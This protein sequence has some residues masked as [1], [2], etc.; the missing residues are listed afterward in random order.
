MQDTVEQPN[1]QNGDSE[2]PPL[3]LVHPG[4]GPAHVAHQEHSRG[5]VSAAVVR[6][7]PYAIV[8]TAIF[9]AAVPLVVYYA[10][11]VPR[12]GYVGLI[13]LGLMAAASERLSMLVYGEAK[14]SISFVCLF[15]IA[16]LYGPA[17]IVLATPLSILAL[18]FPRKVRHVDFLFNMGNST[19]ADTASAIVL[20]SIIDH[21]SDIAISARV[22]TAGLLAASVNYGIRAVLISGAV[23]V[24][25]KRNLLGVW[26]EKFQWL[27]PHYI[28]FGFLGLALAVAYQQLGVT[29][30]LAFA[31]PPLMMRFSMKQYIDNTTRHVAMLRRK[32]EQLQRANREILGMSERLRETYD[33]TLE[34][35]AA[36]LDARDSE[37]GGHS[38][39]VT[40]YTMDMAEE[41]GVPKGSD[42]WL[43]IERASLLHDVGK[44]G[45]SDA[46]L[47]KPGPLTSEEWQQMRK[48]PAI[49]F[50]MLKDVKFLST[51]A[52]IVYA[53]HER[54]DG[55]GYPVGLKGEDVP[56]GAR[57]FA[58]ADAFDA[59]TSN[60]PYR[61]ALSVDK[62]QEEILSNS[63]S[64]FDPTVMEAFLRCLPGWAAGLKER[65][66]A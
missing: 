4:M 42:Q 7:R 8:S 18:H 56:L 24:A 50:E 33:A 63:G 44:I 17:G 65:E 3:V 54:Y 28:V 11:Q 31:A 22:V 46:I 5:S 20:F 59:M 29:G 48:H 66:A 30:L 49:G 64:Q 45:V 62:A 2:R 55:K 61:R 38:S 52:E 21:N 60:R 9:L 43:D 25:F 12:S 34:A 39:R 51:A 53:H 27:F 36:A 16:V 15:A 37:T 47:N 14:V 10:P 41:M 57:I 13:L 1:E 32:N 19:L 35:L 40:V 58:V 23:S 26:R 6:P